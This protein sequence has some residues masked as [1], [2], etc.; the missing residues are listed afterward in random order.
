MID[1]PRRER[2]FNVP[3]AIIG[4]LIV[5]GLVQAVLMFALTAEQTTEFLLLFAFIPARYD[6]SMLSDIAWPGG[7]AAN[8]WT[9]VTYALIHAD[10]SHL[11]FNAV[12]FLSFGSP[13]AQSFGSLRFMVFM[14]MTAS[15]GAA[16]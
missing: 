2:M 15:V 5:L 12:W 11:I 16:V 13:V 1:Q 8:I 9:F 10:L 14:A 7:W 4:L 3:A 6:A